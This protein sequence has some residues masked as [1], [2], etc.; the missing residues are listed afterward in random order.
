M[1]SF[2]A[3]TAGSGYPEIVAIIHTSSAQLLQSQTYQMTAFSECDIH[4]PWKEE[5][6]FQIVNAFIQAPH[7]VEFLEK[8]GW[9]NG[10]QGDWSTGMGS[11]AVYVD[12]LKDNVL[13]V[14][15]NLADTLELLSGRAYV[16]FTAA[17]G[18]KVASS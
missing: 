6:Y 4:Q 17:T 2:A 1:K 16:G 14:P 8:W 15:M 7:V 13:T 18:E 10:G 3:F 9:K 11:L 12:D 5:R